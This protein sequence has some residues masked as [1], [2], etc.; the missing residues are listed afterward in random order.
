MHHFQSSFSVLGVTFLWSLFSLHHSMQFKAHLIRIAE[1]IP[2]ILFPILVK[3]ASSLV[4]IMAS[5]CSLPIFLLYEIQKDS[6]RKSYLA[7]QCFH[8]SIQGFIAPCYAFKNVSGP[9]I[10]SQ[11]DDKKGYLSTGFKRVENIFLINAVSF[12][13]TPSRLSGW[14]NH[15]FSTSQY[16]VFHNYGVLFWTEV[17]IFSFKNLHSLF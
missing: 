17:R 15:Y 16:G 11:I 8:S 9:I 7:L 10:C 4:I 3:Y 13:H 14:R 12:K 2:N 5:S 6:E 1:S